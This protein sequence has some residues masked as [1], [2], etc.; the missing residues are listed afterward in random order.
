MSEPLCRC[1]AGDECAT[2]GV[3]GCNGRLQR[4]ERFHARLPGQCSRRLVVVAEQWARRLRRLSTA[5]RPRFWP[6]GPGA[7][8]TAAFAVFGAALT[9]PPP[10]YTCAPH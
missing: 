4:P 7:V 2:R 3:H 10:S 9:T 5:L 8:A 6:V 1:C